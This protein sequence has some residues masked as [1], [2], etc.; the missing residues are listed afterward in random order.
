MRQIPRALRILAAAFA[1]LLAPAAPLAAQGGLAPGGIPTPP[2]CAAQC[3]AILERLL[4]PCV[5]PDGQLDSQ[6]VEEARRNFDHEQCLLDCDPNGGLDVEVLIC[7]SGC[8]D[9]HANGLQECTAPDGSVDPDCV[10]AKD[11]AFVECFTACGEVPWVPDLAACTLPCTEAYREAVE[12]CGLEGGGIELA[13]FQEKRT[14]YNDCLGACGLWLVPLENICVSRC[15]T[16]FRTALEECGATAGA[17]GGIVDPAQEEC[18][19]NAQKAFNACL[20]DCGID[21]PD[22]ILCAEDCDRSLQ[23]T[24]ARCEGNAECEK[25]AL[26]GYTICLEGCGLVVPPIPEPDP[27]VAGCDLAY[28]ESV[29]TCY[30]PATGQVDA[31]CLGQADTAYVACLGGCGVV[32]PQPPPDVDPGCARSCETGY[33]QTV[34]K[35]FTVQADGT[36]VNV[37]E[38]CVAAAD[39]TYLQCL[40]GCGMGQAPLPGDPAFPV[41]ECEQACGAEILGGLFDCAAENGIVDAECMERVGAAFNE[42]LAACTDQAEKRVLGAL[43]RTAGNRSFI[44]GDADSSGNLQITDAI[45]VFFYLFLGGATIPCMDA[46]DANDDGEVDIAD[47]SAI[48]GSLFLGWEPLSAPS[49]SPGTDSTPDA[50]GCA[51]P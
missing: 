49:G 8:Y 32:F 31:E 44:R 33:R 34:E 23:V 24:I 20:T 13:C 47:G 50:L 17:N 45:R 14:A 42:C 16:A 18:V 26:D 9:S 28:Q 37:D 29:R 7:Q 38:E 25:A 10:A 1:L 12:T 41:G 46:A 48:L 40:E 5:Q 36:I 19:A 21:I 4:A 35:C 30:D 43:A 3:D 51:G 2:D 27:C 6:C 15:E 11:I 22:E 39:S